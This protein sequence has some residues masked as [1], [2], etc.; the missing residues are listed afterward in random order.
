VLAIGQPS[1]AWVSGQLA[2]AWGNERFGGLD[3]YEEVCL[4]AEQ[5]DL[6]MGPWDA[7]PERNPRTGL[8]YS[9]TEMPIDRHLQQWRDGPR[10]LRVQSRYAALLASLHGSRLQRRRD[11]T[12]LP[13]DQADAIR[14]YLADQRAFQAALTASLHLSPEQL[15]RNHQLLWTWDFLSLALCLDWAPT[16]AHDVPTATEPAELHLAPDDGGGSL[17]LAPWPFGTEPLSVRC[18][19]RRLHGPYAGDEELREAL[20]QAPWE[21]LE[22]RLEAG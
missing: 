1:H 2:R 6:G 13:Q 7:E 12:R 3:P 8:P 4:A 21:T 17:T 11:L 10:R 15:E 5:H 18:E 19:G 14:V 20:E 9:F 16:T 22:F